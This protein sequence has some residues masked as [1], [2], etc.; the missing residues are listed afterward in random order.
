MVEVRKSEWQPSGS[1]EKTRAEG[2]IKQRPLAKATNE[3]RA[4]FGV[5]FKGALRIPSY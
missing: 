1:K 3:T 5:M 4:S 2:S